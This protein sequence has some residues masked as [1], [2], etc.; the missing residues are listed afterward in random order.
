MGLRALAAL[1][2]A[3]ALALE[4]GEK[5]PF[6]RERR[7]QSASYLSEAEQRRLELLLDIPLKVS[8][9]LGRTKR[10]IKEVL[11]LTPGAIVELSSQVDEPVEILVNGTLIARG[12]VVAVNENFGV[13]ITSIVSPGERIRQLGENPPS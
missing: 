10:P 1:V 11:G 5:A 4:K 8:V 2:A 9:V 7:P 6:A 3:A 13:R 12:E